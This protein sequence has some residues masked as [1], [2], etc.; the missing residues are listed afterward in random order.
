MALGMR[1]FVARRPDLRRLP[2]AVCGC[3]PSPDLDGELTGHAPS[4]HLGHGFVCDVC[5]EPVAGAIGEAC[6]IAVEDSIVAGRRE[7]RPPHGPPHPTPL[8]R[9]GLGTF[10]EGLQPGVGCRGPG[11]GY[12][13]GSVRGQLV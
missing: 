13:R 10:V 2:D 5:A 9:P 11:T 3:A 4:Q 7:D 12:P 8:H 6:H 1:R